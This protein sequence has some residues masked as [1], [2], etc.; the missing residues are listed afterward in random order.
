MGGRWS[1]IA[2]LLLTLSGL[3]FG[4]M[5]LGRKHKT[6]ALPSHLGLESGASPALTRRQ[7]LEHAGMAIRRLNAPGTFVRANRDGGPDRRS[8]KAGAARDAFRHDSQVRR[9]QR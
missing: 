8:K 5:T 3:Y 1:H 9:V 4:A 6:I 7:A 2:R